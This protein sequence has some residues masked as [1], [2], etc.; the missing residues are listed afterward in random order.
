MSAAALVQCTFVGNSAPEGSNISADCD[1][2][3]SLDCCLVTGG[4]GG[5][6]V[7]VNGGSSAVF[8][9]TDIWGNEAGDWVAPFADQL[10]QDGN[11]SADPQFCDTAGGDYTVAASSPCAPEHSGGCGQIGAWPVGCAGTTAVPPSAAPPAHVVLAPSIPNPFNPAT[12]LSYT[13]P[14]AG[15][16]RLAIHGLDGRLVAVLVSG[17]RPAG[18]HE[19]T[20]RGC[21]ARGR[22]MPSGTYLAVLE[23]AGE[24]HTRSLVLL[25]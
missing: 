19:A 20:W 4:V 5:P 7:Y 24:Q 15:S 12:T 25:R 18:R 1:G 3:I 8:T 17:S 2:N 23:A 14:A 13:I 16:V 10:G 21:D 11:V 6:G 22:S 9:C